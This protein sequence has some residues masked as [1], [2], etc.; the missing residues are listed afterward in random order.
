MR[1]AGE[2]SASKSHVHKVEDLCSFVPEIVGKE[3]AFIEVP[4]FCICHSVGWLCVTTHL[5]VTPCTTCLPSLT[6]HHLSH[7]YFTQDILAQCCLRE[8]LFLPMWIK[9]PTHIS[10]GRCV[11]SVC[12]NS[13]TVNCVLHTTVFIAHLHFLHPTHRKDHS[14][15]VLH[16]HPF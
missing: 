15:M 6:C 10:Y 4:Q 1:I 2:L 9:T 13:F 16:V 12:I 5:P 11:L 7:A 8:T 14:T 3:N